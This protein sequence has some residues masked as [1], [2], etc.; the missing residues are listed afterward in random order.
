MRARCESIVHCFRIMSHSRHNSAKCVCDESLLCT[1]AV[2]QFLLSFRFS[3]FF[4]FFFLPYTHM[5][6]TSAHQ[7][8][9]KLLHNFRVCVC[10]F[11]F[12]FL[13]LERRQLNSPYGWAANGTILPLDG[14]LQQI[15][16]KIACRLNYLIV[17]AFR[18]LVRISYGI[19]VENAIFQGIAF[20]SR[21]LLVSCVSECE[22]GN[23]CEWIQAGAWASCVCVCIRRKR[24]SVWHM[25]AAMSPDSFFYS[26]SCC[27]FTNEDERRRRR[28]WQGCLD[29]FVFY[30]LRR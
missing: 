15:T 19:E 13:E 22:L 30:T 1:T 2:S 23:T 14:C 5:S 29:L 8:H 17:F 11:V 18:L 4:S 28:R 3:S 26:A 20:A 24:T 10:V 25:M 6:E 21:P 12:V 27:H 16:W 7:G 9:A